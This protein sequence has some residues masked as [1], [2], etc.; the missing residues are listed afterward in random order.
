MSS[1]LQSTATFHGG[2][3]KIGRILFLATLVAQKLSIALSLTRD[4]P[5]LW[6]FN[7]GIYAKRLWQ[8]GRVSSPITDVHEF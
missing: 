6:L 2:S 1:S 8:A 3:T 7:S 4:I 5:V